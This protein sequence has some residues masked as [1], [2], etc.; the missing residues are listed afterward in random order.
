MG[1]FVKSLSAAAIVD[2]S[3]LMTEI[4]AA[5]TEV[6]HRAPSFAEAARDIRNVLD[7]DKFLV[8]NALSACTTKE[9]FRTFC[10]TL[11]MLLGDLV[12]QNAEGAKLIEVYDRRI[13]R[14]QD[15]VRYH[16]TRQGGDIHTD[17]VNHP[18]PCKYFLLGCVAPALLGGES[19]IVRA[20]DVASALSVVPQVL[21]T[22]RDLFWFEG[23]GMGRDV[24]LFQL[25]VFSDRDGVPR[26]RYLRSYIEAAHFRAGQPLTPDRVFALDALDSLLESSTLQQRFTLGRGDLLI[27]SDTEVFHGR[28]AFLDSTAEG[29]W[30]RQR[31]MFRLWIN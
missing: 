12:V 4:P 17:S 29:A 31:H 3:R 13:G 18:T 25:P 15:G 28:T 16:Q 21:S 14:I 24:G 11:G 7:H 19:I 1:D 30:E 6:G 2:F 22:L 8:I 5:A 26:F 20:A 10:V 9:E 23:R 27:C